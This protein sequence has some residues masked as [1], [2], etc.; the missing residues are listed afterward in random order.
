MSNTIFVLHYGVNVNSHESQLV[1]R[2]TGLHDNSV[3]LNL[4]I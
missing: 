3:Q 1:G 2:E 4:L